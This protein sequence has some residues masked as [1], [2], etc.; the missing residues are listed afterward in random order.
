MRRCTA[1]GSG[2]RFKSP[3]EAPDSAGRLR[4]ER[5]NP[6][7][8]SPAAAKRPANL[9][10][11]DL[12]EQCGITDASGLREQG[13]KEKKRKGFRDVNHNLP[14]RQTGRRIVSRQ[15]AMVCRIPRG[16]KYLHRYFC[17]G[18]AFLIPYLAEQVQPHN[19]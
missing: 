7:E 13:W 14:G 17:S 18:W 19:P 5:A 1:R 16:R 4:R 8:A 15:R 11:K 12:R 9:T 10:R 2:R 3:G 6:R